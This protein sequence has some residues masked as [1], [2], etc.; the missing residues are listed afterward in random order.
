MLMLVGN[1]QLISYTNKQLSGRGGS[2]W[3]LNYTN[4]LPQKPQALELGLGLECTRPRAH[5]A[6]KAVSM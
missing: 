3:S 4:Y 6:N 5:A 1:T 2:W